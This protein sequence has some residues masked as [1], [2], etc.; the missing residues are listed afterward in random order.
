MTLSIGCGCQTTNA[1]SLSGQPLFRLRAPG[2]QREDEFVQNHRSL[3][4][5]VE[6]VDWLKNNLRFAVRGILDLLRT[7]TSARIQLAV[8]IFVIAAG[9]F[10]EIDRVEWIAVSLAIGIV[11]GAEGFNTALE[12][13]ADAV[14]PEKHPLV[15]RAKDAAAGAVLLAAI[16]ATVV[17]F[18]V[19][20]PKLISWL[21]P[22]LSISRLN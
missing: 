14:H 15:G 1:A 21:T 5:I 9:F 18:I 4:G 2:G 8:S 12:S 22:F 7:Q 17:G 6:K 19:F 10:F 11:L 3:R 16:A 13:L 20:L